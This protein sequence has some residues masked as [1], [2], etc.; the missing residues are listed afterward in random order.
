MKP[1]PAEIG[2]FTLL[3]L[4]GCGADIYTP[5]SGGNV[6]VLPSPLLATGAW[7]ITGDAA[8]PGSYGVYPI[9]G[10][11]GAL[12]VTGN[13]VQAG[14]TIGSSDSATSYLPASCLNLPSSLENAGTYATGT[15]TNNTLTLEADFDNSH[16]QLTAQISA[17]H[18]S[19]TSGSY[20]VTGAC[21]TTSPYLEG[22]W[23]APLTGTYKGQFASVSGADPQVTA[24]FTQADYYSG[25]GYIPVS[26]NILFTTSGCT[27][28]VQLNGGY[29]L[30]YENILGGY[31]SSTAYFGGK[32]ANNALVT[33]EEDDPTSQYMTNIY[34]DYADTGCGAQTNDP[35]NPGQLIRQ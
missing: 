34:W 9:R 31:T 25:Y 2:L 20:A 30:G 14:L 28:A 16:L 13:S 23:N 35:N 17:D 21:A 26:G 3:L 5:V 8:G 33:G 11:L 29:V 10:F 19:F 22:N 1:P 6:S 32:P 4:A 12:T 27:T 7:T 15:I 18:Q 24:T